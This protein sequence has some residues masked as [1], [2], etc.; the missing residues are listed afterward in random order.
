MPMS[1]SLNGDICICGGGQ[2]LRICFTS[3]IK[4]ICTEMELVLDNSTP[5]FYFSFLFTWCMSLVTVDDRFNIDCSLP[6]VGKYNS[7]PV[8]IW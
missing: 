7:C 2:R 8:N 5:L 6:D 1:H 3:N 4:I